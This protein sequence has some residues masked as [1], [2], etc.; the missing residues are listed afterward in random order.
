MSLHDDL[1]HQATKLARLDSRRPK[2][3][4]LRR[5]ISSAYYAV[6]HLLV[7]DASKLFVDDISMKARII[8]TIQHGDMKKVSTSFAAGRLP[9]A[10]QP[11]GSAYSIP[12]ELVDVAN[13]L[14]SLQQARH[15]ADYDVTRVFSRQETHEFVEN[16]RQTFS[17]WNAIRRSDAARLYLACFL[18][19]KRWDE[20]PR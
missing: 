13:E 10:V 15:E 12:H 2:Q 9:R 5:A 11:T 20:E 3:A 1:L 14:V 4:N 7:A 19:W 16:A 6:F 8:R 18:L 17:N